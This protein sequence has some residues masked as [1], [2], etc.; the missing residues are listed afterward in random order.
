[1]LILKTP[2]KPPLSANM[3]ISN[4]VLYISASTFEGGPTATPA[5]IHVGSAGRD[6]EASPLSPRSDRATNIAALKR[7]I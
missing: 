2:D 6:A 3:L 7:F 1:M 5:F 4:F